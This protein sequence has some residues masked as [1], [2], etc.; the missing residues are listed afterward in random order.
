MKSFSVQFLGSGDAFGSGGRCQTCILVETPC[1]CFLLDCGASS[2]IAMRRCG[3]DPARIDAILLT[4]L[5]G[6]HFGGL[7]FF[8]LEA[9]L[10]SKRTR[11]LVIAGPP[12]T[13][14]RVRAAQEVLFTDSS[15]VQ[16]KF[17]IEFVEIQER[18]PAALAGLC[19]TAYPAAHASGAASYVLRVECGG[20][21]VV[22][23]GDTDW[24]DSLV[25]AARG[26][27]LF[28]CEAYFFEKRTKY[29]INYRTLLEHRAALD[30]RRIVLTHMSADLLA[31][32][33]EVEIESAADGKK[34]DL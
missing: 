16:Q 28:I 34:L 10:V 20:K 5:H 24:T 13:Q 22:Y 4:H 25:E 26:A 8:I 12:G 3:V 11:P 15:R 17:D 33:S 18:T 1:T 14:A 32:L 2:L 19:V 29:H 30:C 21:T 27:D 9:Q 7:P 23:S 31:R 6:D